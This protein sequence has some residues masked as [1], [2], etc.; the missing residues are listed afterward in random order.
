MPWQTVWTQSPTKIA[1]Q[2]TTTTTTYKT[3]HSFSPDFPRSYARRFRVSFLLADWDTRA[4]IN[5]PDVVEAVGESGASGASKSLII[6]S[7]IR[8]DRTTPGWGGETW[9]GWWW[10]FVFPF[11]HL[12]VPKN[13]A[14]NYRVVGEW[15]GLDRSIH[16]KIAPAEPFD[17]HLF[18]APFFVGGKCGPTLQSRETFL[19][20]FFVFKGSFEKT[21]RYDKDA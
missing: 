3:T 12:A 4:V 6:P 11:Q 1:K 14:A 21:Y 20:N 7:D 5:D 10:V 17:R 15:W 9:N 8:L 19:S 18:L 2:Q 13:A 16:G